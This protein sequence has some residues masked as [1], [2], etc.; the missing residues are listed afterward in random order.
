MVR[1]QEVLVDGQREAGSDVSHDLGL[2]D[3]ID[4]QFSL[5]V[6]IHLDE[7]SRVARVLNDHGNNRLDQVTSIGCGDGSWSD[8]CFQ[9]GGFRF[10]RRRFGGRCGCTWSL[11]R[12]IICWG[13]ST[14][15]HACQVR[16][17]VVERWMIR[18]HEILVHREREPV[19]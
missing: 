17:H 2:L 3:R 8:G 18:E 10:S 9:R 1:E 14:A 4:A 13:G 16:Q 15:L 6:L 12:S 7:I 11:R 5:E 19:P